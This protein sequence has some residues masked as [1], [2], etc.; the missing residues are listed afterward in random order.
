MKAFFS[1]IFD[2]FKIV[3]LALAIVIPIRYFLFQPF[4][5]SGSSME[6]NFHN[7]D[8]LIVNEIAPRLHPLRRGEVIVFNYPLDP[9]KK[10]I[11]RVIGLPGETLTVKN[12]YVEVKMISG[13]TKILKENAYL[14]ILPTLKDFSVSLGPNQYFVMGDNRRFSY[15]SRSWG[16]VPRKNIIGQVWIRLWPLSKIGLIP[17]PHY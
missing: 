15:D 14:S 11:K 1:F 12:H 13:E 4:L 7:G 3:I 2:V 9:S 6:P 5:V 16:P 8:Y 17:I 10:F